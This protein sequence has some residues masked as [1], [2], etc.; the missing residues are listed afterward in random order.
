MSVVADTKV[1][2]YYLLETQ[3]FAGEAA[4]FWRIAQ[5]VWAPASWEIELTNVIWLSIRA[6]I[7]DL[8]TG[9]KRLQLA[10][11]LR[12]QSAPVKGLWEGSLVRA[13]R[14]RH[15]AYDTVFV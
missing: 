4:D 3:P 15:P 12:I 14:A 6:G 9:I 11:Q 13:T 5:D 8:G 2:A 10:A 7:L 1:I